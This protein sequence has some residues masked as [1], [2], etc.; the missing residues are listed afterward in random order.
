M[1]LWMK[2]LSHET[3]VSVSG[4]FHRSNNH[5]VDNQWSFCL[6]LAPVLPRI[7]Y[8]LSML[9]GIHWRPPAQS[10]WIVWYREIKDKLTWGVRA[11]ID[12]PSS[13]IDIVRR[14]S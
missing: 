12:S 2:K 14:L 8:C 7:L 1:S 6:K 13:I 4:R 9:E 3:S 5:T 10:A 11:G